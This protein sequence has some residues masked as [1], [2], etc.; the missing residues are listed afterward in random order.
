MFG[1]RSI[2]LKT[3]QKKNWRYAV[4]KIWKLALSS[5]NIDLKYWYTQM[6]KN[7]FSF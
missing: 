6:Y 7:L 3:K 4:C 5:V 2:G 1:I